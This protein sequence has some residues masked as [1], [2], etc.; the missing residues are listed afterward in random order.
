MMR[1]KLAGAANELGMITEL[2]G[3]AGESVNALKEA[4]V[5]RTP[6]QPDGTPTMVAQRQQQLE[7]ASQRKALPAP[8]RAA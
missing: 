4:G 8:R 3:K 7:A 5:M 2:A 1:E 6:F